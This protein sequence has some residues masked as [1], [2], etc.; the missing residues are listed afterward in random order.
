M[1]PRHQKV[2]S[3]KKILRWRSSRVLAKIPW[4]VILGGFACL[5]LWAKGELSRPSFLPMTGFIVKVSPIFEGEVLPTAALNQLKASL[6]A[7]NRLYCLFNSWQLVKAFVEK[8]SFI[9][10]MRLNYYSLI[11]HGEAKLTIAFREPVALLEERDRFLCLDSKGQSFLCPNRLPNEVLVRVANIRGPA[12]KEVFKNVKKLEYRLS[13]ER[14]LEIKNISDAIVCF[15]TSQKKMYK[16]S[17]KDALRP[18]AFTQNLEQ[19]TWV[20]KNL[21]SHNENF[22]YIDLTLAGMGKIIVGG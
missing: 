15:K 14:V 17:K 9:E 19:L 5:S 8:Y 12:F 20:L 21:L 6:M 2:K 16:F 1:M 13:G 18:R 7:N 10:S 3:R 11:F 4:L 22:S